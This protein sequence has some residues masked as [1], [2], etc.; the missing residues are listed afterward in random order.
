[1]DINQ[2]PPGLLQALFETLGVDRSTAED[3]AQ[4]VADWRTQQAP[5]EVG[6]NIPPEYRM[7]GRQWAPGGQDFERLDELLLVR[8]ITPAIY[9]ASLPY[10]TVALEQGPWLQYASRTVLTAL[11]KAK[12]DSG[13]TVDAADVR[14]PVVL[15]ITATASGANGARFIRHVLMR[16]DGEL[17]GPTWKYR[18]LSWD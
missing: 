5:G 3:A 15:S 16:Y 10:L 8:G 1:M 7:D 2:V 13:L 17:S 12:H 14:G 18:I 11:D 6:S 4:N 9:Q